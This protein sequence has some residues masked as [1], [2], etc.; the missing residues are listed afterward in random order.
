MKL[1]YANCSDIDDILIW[2]ND[3][4]TRKM[5]K[6]QD[7]VKPEEHSNWFKSSLRDPRRIIYIGLKDAIK[8]GVCHFNCNENYIE[9]EVSINLNPIMRKKKLAEKL[10]HTAMCEFFKTH[11]INLKAEIKKN[12]FSSAVIFQKCGFILFGGDK[13]YDIYRYEYLVGWTSGIAR[14][15]CS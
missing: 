4:L 13:N 15:S 5:S 8:V 11:K 14:R 2:R 9:A 3:E 10:L 1:R 6:Y 12:N 7:L